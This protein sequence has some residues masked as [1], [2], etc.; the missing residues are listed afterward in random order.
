VFGVAEMVRLR[1]NPS[2]PSVTL[3]RWVCSA[4]SASG[5]D[6]PVPGRQFWLYE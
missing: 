5:L 1:F 3:I 2:R 6:H 4:V